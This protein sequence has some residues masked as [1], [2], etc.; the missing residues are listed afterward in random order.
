[1]QIAISVGHRPRPPSSSGTLLFPSPLHSSFSFP[2]RRSVAA[3]NQ[4]TRTKLQ[5]RRHVRRLAVRMAGAEAGNGFLD[6]IGAVLLRRWI[7]RVIRGG[8]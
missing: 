2:L 7:V 5:P 3:A 8:L 1:M 6:S 4:A